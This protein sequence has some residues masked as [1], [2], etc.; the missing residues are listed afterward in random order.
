MEIIEDVLEAFKELLAA[1]EALA[2]GEIPS[3]EECDRYVAAADRARQVI[4]RAE[5]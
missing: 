4:K 5:R 2:C 1:S 3:R